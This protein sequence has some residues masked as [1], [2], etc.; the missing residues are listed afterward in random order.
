[1]ANHS[2][3]KVWTFLSP[4]FS[5]FSN[6]SLSRVTKSHLG[7]DQNVVEVPIAIEIQG[8]RV[9]VFVMIVK[10]PT[11]F[12]F[13]SQLWAMNSPTVPQPTDDGTLEQLRLGSV[14]VTG[15]NADRLPL[16]VVRDSNMVVTE[17]AGRG[18]GRCGTPT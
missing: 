14:R 4:G 5:R 6:R 16:G 7:I 1:M 8:N 18:R 3:L 15:G 2:D 11:V 9:G 12:V 10:R 17:P 13:A